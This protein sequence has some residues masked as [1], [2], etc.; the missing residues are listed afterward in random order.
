MKKNIHLWLF[1]YSVFLLLPSFP[2]LRAQNVQNYAITAGSNEALV[3]GGGWTQLIGA[4]QQSVA[5][6]AVP[7]GF[8]VWFMGERFTDF[9]VNVNGVLR[10]GT[11][12]LPT[13]ANTPGIT[14]NARIC[15]FAHATTGNSTWST[16]SNGSVRYKVIGTAPNRRL[17]VDWDNIRMSGDESDSESGISRFQIHVYETAPANADGGVARIIY[18]RMRILE[19]AS[20]TGCAGANTST[21]RMGIGYGENDATRVV[22]LNTDNHPT[23]TGGSRSYGTEIVGC[24]GFGNAP[25]NITSLNSN[26]NTSR[27]FYNFNPPAP[28]GNVTT[29]NLSCVSSN[30]VML[31][32]TENATNEV[33]IVI[34][35]STDN[36]NFTFL[37]QLASG[38]TSFLNTGLAA[39]T[40]YYYRVFT[41]T[42]GR[43]SAIT[44]N[45]VGNITTPNTL[46]VYSILSSNWTNLLTWTTA[47]IPLFSQ[48]VVIGCIVPHTVAVNG[49]GDCNDLTVQNG[50][51]LN[52]NVNRTLHV[53]GNLYNYGTINLNTGAT[54]RIDGQAENYG[55]INVNG[56]T[57][58][59]NGNLINTPLATVDNGTGTIRLRGNLINNGAYNAQTGSFH[60]DGNSNQL[61]N[62]TGTSSFLQTNSLATLFS[63]NNSQRGNMFNVTTNANAIIIDDFDIS[64]RT[65]GNY[66]V[67]VYYRVGGYNGFENNAAAWTLLGT[68]SVVSPSADAVVNLP[69]GGLNIP[70][71]TTYGLYIT[72]TTLNSLAY[73]DGANTY[74][75]SNLTIQTGV[76]ISYPFGTIYSPRTWNGRINYRTNTVSPNNLYFY[77]FLMENTSAGGVRTQ[78]TDVY[79]AHHATWTNGIF[80]S[81]NNH[82]LQFI[83]GA[84]STLPNNG[85]YADLNVRKIGNQAF[86]FPT[87]NGGYAGV[88]GI[89]A[90]SLTTDHFTAR[91]FRVSPQTV[92]YDRSLKEASI[93]HISN[94]EYWILD[95][96]NGAAAVSVSLSYDDVRSCGVGD[97]SA[98]KV[99]RWDGAQW[100]DHFNGGNFATPYAGL[101]SAGAVS[102]FSPFTLGSLVTEDI[103]PLPVSW[104]GFEAKAQNA[105]DALLNWQTAQETD[106]SHFVVERSQNGLDFQAIG[107]VEGTNRSHTS[108]YDFVDERAAIYAENGILYY[109]LRQVDFSGKESYSPMRQVV[110]EVGEK[111]QI[112]SLAPNPFQNQ[113]EVRYQ[114]P[115]QA[116]VSFTLLDMTGRILWQ[117]IETQAAGTHLQSIEGS[118]LAKGAYLLKITYQNQSEVRKIVKE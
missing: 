5:S 81:D 76:G 41:V 43:L 59:V 1:C 39:N 47:A 19:H 95:R 92:P 89:S 18:G 16:E 96:T 36:V 99:C 48:N 65:S 37:T 7:I 50:S 66:T 51:V 75:D 97:P 70:A 114:I 40:T 79:I 105:L 2:L 4:N 73:T 22:F 31:N 53:R 108:S 25:T 54:L 15:A 69:V 77:N 26:N 9:N 28:N 94:C 84:T 17:V 33:G 32:W 101:T 100:I 21:T 116:A 30:S 52:F 8:E 117:K 118:Q 111:M 107:R 68:A 72:S 74:N 29:F 13:T 71:S 78:N 10:F 12:I 113:F 6:A 91:Y 85:S 63:P 87:G 115:T 60:F 61:I 82:L 83:S 44:V 35:R 20:T 57:L 80:Y 98:L 64:L 90:P 49:N 103:N 23:V 110:F 112:F 86:N 106:N 109:R 58:I 104:L 46:S 93:H 11:A 34:Y 24:N 55:T 102:N 62:H 88:I 27:K 45:N 42:E 14:D 38:T 67:A 56:G 3:G